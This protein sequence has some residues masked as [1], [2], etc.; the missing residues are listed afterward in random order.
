MVQ[1]A[2]DMHEVAKRVL[3]EHGFAT[4]PP[5]AESARAEPVLDGVRDLRSLPWSSIDN[6]ESRDLDQVEYAEQLDADRIRLLVGIADVAAYVAK[7]SPIDD[8]AAQNCATLYTGVRTF[9][10]LPEALANNRTS[11][12]EGGERLAMITEMIVLRDGSLDDATTTVYPALVNNHAKLVYEN[13]GA[14]LEGDTDAVPGSP[15][16]AEQLRLHAEVTSWLRARRIERGALELETIEARPVAK[17][18]KLIDLQII[19]KN[20]ARELVED[21]MIAV[22]GATARFLERRMSSSIRRI[23]HSPSRWPRIVELAATF[24]ATLPEQPNV[25]ALGAFVADRRRADPED[26][27]ELS[28]TIV[29][30]LGAGEYVLQ[31]AADPDLGHFG[32]AVED[33]MHSTAPNRRFPDL[34]TQ[35]LLKAAAAGK[36]ASYSDDELGAIAVRCT[37]RENAARKV[38]RQMRKI[39][40]ATLLADRVGDKFKAIVTGASRKGTYVRLMRPPAEGRVVVGERGLDVGDRV[41]VKLVA[42]DPDRGYVDFAVAR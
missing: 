40:A 36:P 13:V 6:E 34:V 12:L 14:W 32:L 1:R 33:Y 8:Y 29:K 26:F 11:L 23:V 21:I 4:E 3:E 15:V 17:N 39:V 30:L 28:L 25:R 9:P 37:E 20:R 38:E 18:G 42:T 7:D 35:R 22:N 24:G 16:I 19:R 5:S 27:P 31:R 41:E 2:R 10:M